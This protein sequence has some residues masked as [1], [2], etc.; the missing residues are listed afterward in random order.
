MRTRAPILVSLTVVAVLAGA[1][2]F[3]VARTLAPSTTPAE[4]S[5]ITLPATPS[6]TPEPEASEGPEVTSRIKVRTPGNNDG[7]NGGRSCPAG[8]SCDQHPNGIV[9]RCTGG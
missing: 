2:G 8:C 4:V 6:P 9:I 3:N 5:V 7:E 1:G